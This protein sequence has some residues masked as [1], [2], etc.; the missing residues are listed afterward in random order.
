MEGSRIR[1]LSRWISGPLDNFMIRLG[2]LKILSYV[3]TRSV[4]NLDVITKNLAEI[5]TNGIATNLASN[6]AL[7][8]Y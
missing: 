6:D 5:C 3:V 8:D 2:Y 7:V 1:S 4:R